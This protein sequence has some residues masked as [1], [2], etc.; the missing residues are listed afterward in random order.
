M[1]ALDDVAGVADDRPLLT[2]EEAAR[3]LRIGRSLAYE[4]A[5]AYL[6][7][8]GTVGMP[9]LRF[10]SCLRVPRWALIELATTG[11]VVKLGVGATPR[12]KVGVAH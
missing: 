10:G 6:D 3:Y 7:S 9:V 2:V 11:T 12:V 8:D 4:L 1:S 5:G